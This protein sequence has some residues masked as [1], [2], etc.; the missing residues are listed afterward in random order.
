[1][2]SSA[3]DRDGLAAHDDAGGQQH[4]G[5]RDLQADL[6]AALADQVRQV[7][8]VLGAEMDR[9]RQGGY[10]A[11]WHGGRLLIT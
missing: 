8:D 11:F 1:M 5:V 4:I 10:F 2:R 3:P 9:H 7:H 6:L